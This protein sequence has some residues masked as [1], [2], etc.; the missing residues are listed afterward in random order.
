MGSS[1]ALGA[2]SPIRSLSRAGEGAQYSISGNLPK[3]LPVVFG[4]GTN[5]DSNEHGALF[6]FSFFSPSFA[7]RLFQ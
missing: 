5:M 2:F 4:F 3:V 6:P 7:E 1:T